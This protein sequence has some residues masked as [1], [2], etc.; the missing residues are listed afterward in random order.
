MNNM[1]NDIQKEKPNKKRRSAAY[2]AKTGMLAAMA[3]VLLLLEFPLFP[4]APFLKLNIS[5]LP[6]LIAAFMFG[7]ISGIVCNAV[8]IGLFLLLKGTSSGFVGDLSNLIS[9]TVYTLVAGLIYMRHKSKKGAIIA[10]VSGSIAFCLT[11]TACNALILFP[12]YGITDKTVIAAQIPIVLAFNAI[13]TALTSL[14]AFFLYKTLHRL[15][16]KF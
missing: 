4:S 9:G 10:L 2:L 12:F 3:T 6:S 15:F 5:D 1:N 8:K 14:A 7:P 11:M 16:D 13:K